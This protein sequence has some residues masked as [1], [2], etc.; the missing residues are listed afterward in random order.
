MTWWLLVDAPKDDLL[1]PHHRLRTETLRAFT[2]TAM[3]AI[4]SKVA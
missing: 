4:L 2:Q 1:R 3:D